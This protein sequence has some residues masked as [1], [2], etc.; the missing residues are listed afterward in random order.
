MEKTFQASIRGIRPLLMH[1]G[2]LAD[3]L[4]DATKALKVLTSKK[5]KSDDDHEDISR[6][7]WQGG[8]YFDEKLGP[9]IP[10]ENLQ[11]AIEQGA[12]KRK[13]GK[14]FKA[15]V[16]VLGEDG[17][18]GA[19]LEY[20]G[21]RT[22]AAMWK[23]DRFRLRRGARVTG[24]RVVR[25]RARFPSG[26]CATFSVAVL[27]GAVTRAQLEEAVSDAGLYEGIGDWRP[28]YGRFQVESVK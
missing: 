13:L 16:E 4:D 23:D 15:L 3:P 14:Q 12:A 28:K 19:R 11:R 26:W 20:E 8:M 21:P 24:K 18:P 1:D 6:A 7:E 2:K 27:D 9:Y 17:A 22:L 5:T 25:T 10:F